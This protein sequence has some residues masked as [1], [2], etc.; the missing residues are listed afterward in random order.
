M[1]THSSVLAW[2]LPGMGKPGGLLSMGSHR[3]GHDWSD[4]TA[5]VAAGGAVVKNLPANAGDRRDRR[6]QSLVGK[7]PAG[8]PGNMLQYSWLENSMDRGAWQV[9]VQ[10]VAKSQIW[11][12]DWVHKHI[13]THTYIKKEPNKTRQIQLGAS[14]GVHT[15]VCDLCLEFS[16]PDT[17]GSC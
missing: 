1:A 16:K 17:S 11:L 15:Q 6:V 2:R 4:L 10:G 5:A 13:N 8:G 12:S 9:T 7:S 14:L 3:V